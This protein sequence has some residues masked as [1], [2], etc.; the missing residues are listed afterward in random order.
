[1]DRERHVARQRN[2][3]QV[4]RDVEIGLVEGQRF[5]DRS[6]LCEDLADLL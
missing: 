1:V 3:L 6:V 4:F 2:S 5:D